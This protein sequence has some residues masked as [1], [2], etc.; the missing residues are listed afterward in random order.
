MTRHRITITH[1]TDNLIFIEITGGQFDD[2]DN[3][4]LKDVFGRNL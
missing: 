3:K 1:D 4:R 2:F